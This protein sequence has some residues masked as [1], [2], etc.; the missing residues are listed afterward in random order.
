MTLGR[1]PEFVNSWDPAWVVPT[2]G[3]RQEAAMRA[4]DEG[5]IHADDL[6]RA[7]LSAPADQEPT[8][9]RLCFFWRERGILKARLHK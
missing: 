3:E 5:Q 2:E 1:G 7:E 8:L 9:D 4:V 6:R